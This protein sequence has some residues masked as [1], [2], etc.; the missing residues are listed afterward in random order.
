MRLLIAMVCAFTI[1][2]F[3]QPAWAQATASNACLQ[4][5]MDCEVNVTAH[6]T[7]EEAVRTQ[8]RQLGI[9]VVSFTAD[10]SRSPILVSVTGLGGTGEYTL[11]NSCIEKIARNE[12]CEAGEIPGTACRDQNSELV[13]AAFRRQAARAEPHPE[14]RRV[15]CGTAFEC[16]TPRQTTAITPLNM[17]LAAT[18]ITEAKIEEVAGV[19]RAIVGAVVL[20]L[21][22]GLLNDGGG[23]GGNSGGNTGGAPDNNGGSPGRPGGGPP[24]GP[25]GT[26]FGN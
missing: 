7:R 11:S 22:F 1:W 14:V 8:A 17:N 18:D 12:A 3:G 26:P 20:G 25:G 16:Y 21:T 13:S 9:R 4:A 2:S 5:Q 19:E 24:D 15:D 10:A 23:D 6:P